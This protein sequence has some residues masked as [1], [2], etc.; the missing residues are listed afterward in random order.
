MK[1][2]AWLSDHFALIAWPTVCVFIWKLRGVL[3]DY[4]DR[5]KK[6]EETVEL[7]AT[8]HLPH[9]QV[10][11]EKINEGVRDLKEGVNGGFDRMTSSFDALADKIFMIVLSHKD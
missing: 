9:L 5:F 8:N 2:F 10:E 1:F 7:L 3:I 11:L 4:R 6:A